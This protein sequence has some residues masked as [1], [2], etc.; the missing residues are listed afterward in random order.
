M[1]KYKGFAGAGMNANRNVNNVIR[2]AQKMQEEMERVS[3]H[4]AGIVSNHDAKGLIKTLIACEKTRNIGKTNL[5]IHRALQAKNKGSYA[6]L[7]FTI[8]LKRMIAYGMEALG[9]DKER[10]AYEEAWKKSACVSLARKYLKMHSV[11]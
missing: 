2:Q 10:I 9:L 3:A 11:N 6:I 4:D 5:A 1:G 7:I 8:A